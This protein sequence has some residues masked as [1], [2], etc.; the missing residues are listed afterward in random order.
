MANT[1]GSHTSFLT[2][3]RSASSEGVRVFDVGETVPLSA[4]QKATLSAVLARIIE[5]YPA[6]TDSDEPLASSEEASQ[7][8]SPDD[9]AH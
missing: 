4:D 6:H 1:N 9:T 8:D 5:R 2:P 3:A 7:T